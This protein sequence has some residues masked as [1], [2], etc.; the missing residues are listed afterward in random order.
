M[1]IG[2]ITG[3]FPPMQG[4]VGDYSLELGRAMVVQGHK[5]FVLTS[6]R[7]LPVI[8]ENGIQVQSTVANWGR[9]GKQKPGDGR[10]GEVQAAQWAKTNQLEVVNIQ[11]Q[12]AAY[13]MRVAANL[14]PE[15][16]NSIAPVVTTFHDLLVPYLFPKAGPLRKKVIYRMARQSRGVVVT[17]R[18]DE[19]ELAQ[20]GH[21]PPVVRI[22]IG[23]NIAVQ[24]PADYDKMAW[25][26]THHIP[27]DAFLVGFFGFI[28]RSKGVDTLAQAIRLLV[29]RGVNAHLLIVGGQTGDSDETNIQQADEAERMVGGLGIARRVHWT[30]FVSPEAVSGH[31]MACDVVALPFRDGVSYRRGTLM[32]TL[33]HGCP[34][35]TTF[36]QVDEPDL[37]DGQAMKMVP[38]DSPLKLAEALRELAHDEAQRVRLGQTAAQLATQFSWDAIATAT[39]H[40]FEQLRVS[41]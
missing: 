29:D 19:R 14:L 26:E 25:R 28:N 38:P 33:A 4:G 6:D 22:P 9:W 27:A 39:L 15:S 1:R 17:N 12:A 34:I 7:A 35:V 21:M 37:V 18:G 24:P 10:R 8:Q 23:S 31:L 2:I 11:Y 20:E 40:F 32:A 13:N 16:L 36:P 3:E 30:G 5:I 41:R